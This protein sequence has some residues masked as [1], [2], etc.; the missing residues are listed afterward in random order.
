MIISLLYYSASQFLTKNNN[1]IVIFLQHIIFSCYICCYLFLLLVNPG[2]PGK[3]HFLNEYY[4]NYKGDYNKLQRC[5]KCNIIV[6]KKFK[7]GHCKYC[8]ICIMKYDHHCP[9]IGKCVG[10]YNLIVF[11]IFLFFASFF[12]LNGLLIFFL[13]VKNNHLFIFK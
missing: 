8:N 1:K 11:Y 10:K 2:V 5:Q 3:E 7:S 13:Y 12:Y 9:W 6:P 4:K